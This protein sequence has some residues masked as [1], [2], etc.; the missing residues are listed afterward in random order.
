MSKNILTISQENFAREIHK[1][2]FQTLK[3]LIT[4]IYDVKKTLLYKHDG[5]IVNDIE[6]KETKIWAELQRRGI[7]IKGND[8][9]LWMKK[10]QNRKSKIMVGVK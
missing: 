2:S 7:D 1:L 8:F 10:L 5:Q 6:R 9:Q 4:G 3:Q